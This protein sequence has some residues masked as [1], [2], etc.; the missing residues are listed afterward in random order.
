MAVEQIAV[1]NAKN[2]IVGTL[3]A[4]KVKFM[5]LETAGSCKIV[6]THKFW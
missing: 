5:V 3:K 1:P 2:S 6:E 4:W